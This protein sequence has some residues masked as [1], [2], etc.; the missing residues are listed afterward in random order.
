MSRITSKKPPRP[1]GIT[2]TA[3]APAVAAPPARRWWWMLV[4]G[5]VGVA[6]GA[7]LA[8]FLH[9]KTGTDAAPDQE[10]S[11][12]P[13]AKPDT[14]G[15]V[16]LP[17]GTF[18][19]GS[20]EDRSLECDAASCCGKK[21]AVPLHTVELS[22]FWMDETPVTNAQFARFVAATGYVTYAE[23]AA[24]GLPPGSFVF[25]PRPG[26]TSL[27]NHMQWWD[28]VP[29]ADWRHSEGPDSNIAGKD[30]HPVVQVCWFDAQAYCRWAKKRLPT[31]AEFEYAA[32]GGLIQ[33]RFAWGD[34]KT[35]GGKWMANIWQGKFPYEN[36]KEDGFAT[37]APVRTFPANG[38]GLFEMSGNVWQW[39]ADWYRPDYYENSPRLNPQGPDD[40][41]DPAESDPVG[42]DPSQRRLRIDPRTGRPVA[43]RVQ[44]GGSFLCSDVYCKGYM[45]GSRG[46]G[47]PNDAANHIGFRCVRSAD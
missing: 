46:K 44:R 42:N 45:P 32:R 31:E 1:T 38:H 28:F 35:P 19:M 39:C 3:A 12:A 13:A 22:P 47:E 9:N 4:L 16:R 10:R 29:G 20:E 37:T 27:K 43:K 25:R 6:G 11:A 36:T 23:K 33:K 14:S 17:G 30:D 21:D 8:V 40:S 24:D 7:A 34:E 15:M 26:I 2:T 18:M 5:I 41:F